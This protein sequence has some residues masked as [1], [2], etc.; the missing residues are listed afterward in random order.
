V[1]GLRALVG[2]AAHVVV[3]VVRY[4]DGVRRVASI[5]EVTG[6]SADGE[7]YALKELFHYDLAGARFVGNGATP[8]FYG[9]LQARGLPADASIFR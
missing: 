2:Q 5:S 3:H 4:A 8:Q 7:S 9:Q 1:R 6:V